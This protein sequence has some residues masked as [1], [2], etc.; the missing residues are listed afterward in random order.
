LRLAAGG[1]HSLYVPAAVCEHVGHGSI[2]KAETW[3]DELGERNR[4]LVLA[5][6]F[7]DRFAVE[8]VRSPWFQ[9]ARPEQVRELLPKLAARCGRGG[10]DLMLD[11][12]LAMRDA[13]R[14]LAGE[15]DERWGRHRNLPKIL[16][17]RERWIAMLL[18]EVARLRLWRL[19]G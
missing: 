18:E 13:V 3:K 1:W 4:L 15:L 17:E 12:L 6:H 10:D 5:R 14:D 2:K 9:S 8:L 7:R 11:L 19:P 16:E